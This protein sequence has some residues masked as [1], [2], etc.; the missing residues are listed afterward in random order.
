MASEQEKRRSI[1]ATQN[2]TTECNSA[3]LCSDSNPIYSVTL[4]QAIDQSDS[5]QRRLAAKTAGNSLS[6]LKFTFN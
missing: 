6:H 4:V 3:P 5:I 1:T 2:I